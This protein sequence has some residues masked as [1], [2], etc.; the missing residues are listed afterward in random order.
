[1]F[2]EKRD[3]CGQ[4]I[5]VF[6]RGLVWDKSAA[7][8]RLPNF[9]Q[10]KAGSF[11]TGD[12]LCLLSAAHLFKEYESPIVLVCGGAPQS[13]AGHTGIPALAQV[14]KDEL[15]ALGIP[16]EQI[17]IDERPCLLLEQLACLQE[18][19]VCN[20]AG[21]ATLIVN[22]YYLARAELLLKKCKDLIYLRRLKKDG[23]LRITAAED[24]VPKND[25]RW[26]AVIKAVYGSSAMKGL[27]AW[28]RKARR[29][30]KKGG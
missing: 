24:I 23:S 30:F 14:M 25:P 10:E 18:M 13:P 6:G 21:G 3:N 19:L 28:E 16:A 27:I 7:R 11:S 22:R 20:G 1:M 2:G 8:W 12:R 9:S 4:A 5:A 15:M 29:V 26:E 17:K